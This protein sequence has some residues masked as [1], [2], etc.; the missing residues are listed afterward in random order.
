MVDLKK[1]TTFS[2]SEKRIV[3]F[4]IDGKEVVFEIPFA[5]GVNPEHKRLYVGNDFDFATDLNLEQ[6]ENIISGNDYI[7]ESACREFAWK[8]ITENKYCKK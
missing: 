3:K 1:L 5:I 2:I 4:A 6:I 8:Q 7:I